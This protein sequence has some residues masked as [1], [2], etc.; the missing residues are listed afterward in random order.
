[1]RETK[2]R[3]IHRHN[4][5]WINCSGFRAIDLSGCSKRQRHIICRRRKHTSF[6]KR[7]VIAYKTFKEHLKLNQFI[8]CGNFALSSYRNRFRTGRF[9][10]RMVSWGMRK[11]LVYMKDHYGSLRVFITESGC[12]D[13]RSEGDVSD[14]F[15]IGYLKEY[16][17]N[18]LQG[19]QFIIELT[20]QTMVTLI[21]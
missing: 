12:S 15:K 18:V 4:W 2:Q 10:T 11:L 6:Y 17:N 21:V 3:Y 19:L 9:N 5:F 8:L 14:P 16:I 7:D 13:L 1:M 20:A